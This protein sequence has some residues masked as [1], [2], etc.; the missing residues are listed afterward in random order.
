VISVKARNDT[1]TAPASARLSREVS[2]QDLIEYALI[3]AFVG[4][5]ATTFMPDLST[6]IATSVGTI[7]NGV[8]N[9]VTP[10]NGSGS[11]SSG[12]TG[13]SSGSGS[14][15]GGNSGSGGGGHHGGHGGGGRGGR[16]H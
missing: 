4:L 9:S 2:G 8:S 5:S 10:A 16:D 15:S 14:G 1:T 6:Q 7:S 13:T 11:S 3:A 12:G